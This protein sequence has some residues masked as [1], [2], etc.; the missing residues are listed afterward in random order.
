MTRKPKKKLR[1]WRVISTT[2]NTLEMKAPSRTAAAKAAGN[3]GWFG[4]VKN[5]VDPDAPPKIGG[6]A[7]CPCGSGRKHKRCCGKKG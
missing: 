3:L 2:G 4:A 1:R 6:N 5:V 7:K